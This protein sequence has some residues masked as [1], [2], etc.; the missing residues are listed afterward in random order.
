MFDSNGKTLEAGPT[1][2]LVIDERLEDVDVAGEGG[3][4][5]WRLPRAAAARVHVAARSVQGKGNYV[6]TAGYFF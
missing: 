1:R 2:C 6:I 4:R 3:Q 5:Q